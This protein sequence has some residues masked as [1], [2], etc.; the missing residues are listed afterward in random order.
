MILALILTYAF[1]RPQLFASAS[2]ICTS[3]T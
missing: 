1:A 2:L 3:P